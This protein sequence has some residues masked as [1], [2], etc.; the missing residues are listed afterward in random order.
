[1]RKGLRFELFEEKFYKLPYMKALSM[2]K[3]V[4]ER[5]FALVFFNDLISR[6]LSDTFINTN[7]NYANL[8]QIRCKNRFADQ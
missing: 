6:N 2:V 8:M 4:F 3:N 1:M 7:I 5:V